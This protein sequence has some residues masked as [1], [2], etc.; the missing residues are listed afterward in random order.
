MHYA[1]YS[2]SFIKFFEFQ[3]IVYIVDYRAG[4]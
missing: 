2:E 1:A 3:S 4:H